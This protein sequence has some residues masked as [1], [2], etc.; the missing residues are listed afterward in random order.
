MKVVTTQITMD[1]EFDTELGQDIM[2]LKILLS[3]EYIEENSDKEYLGDL[4]EFNGKYE[5]E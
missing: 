3:D 5:E 2:T 1:Q 4:E